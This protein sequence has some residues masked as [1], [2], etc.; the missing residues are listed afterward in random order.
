VPSGRE[1]NV[2]DP[3][4]VVQAAANHRAART[5]GEGPPWR[6]ARNPTGDA[7]KSEKKPG[8]I[9]SL[10]EKMKVNAAD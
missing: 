2:D 10:S 8:S 5:L 7:G 4:P 6:G 3:S 1:N 9:V